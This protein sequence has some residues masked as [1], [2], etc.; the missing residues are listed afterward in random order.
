MTTR[1]II[2]DAFALRGGE[3][4]QL[5]IEGVGAEDTMAVMVA[6][7]PA[8]PEPSLAMTPDGPVEQFCVIGAEIHNGLWQWM[9][10]APS[11]KEVIGDVLF[12]SGLERGKWYG[13]RLSRSEEVKP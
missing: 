4:V 10:L 3:R 7:V 6:P 9:Q 11:T 13:L 12:E 2:H 5:R 8:L 1:V